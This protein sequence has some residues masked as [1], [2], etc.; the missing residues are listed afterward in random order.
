MKM[1]KIV[2]ISGS[3]RKKGYTMS[4]VKIIEDMMKKVDESIEFKY[5]YLRDKDLK[6]CLGCMNCLKVG[7]NACP[8]KDDASMILE[9]M[10]SADGLIFA[11]PGYSHQVSGLYKNFMDRFM[12][13]DHLPEF[14]G[15]PAL[16][17]STVGGDGAGVIPK[18]MA[19]M[20]I[21]WWGCEIV[22]QM[23]IPF[24]YFEMSNKYHKK[25]MKKIETTA[26]DFYNELNNNIEGCPGR[27]KFW[28]SR[29][30]IEADYYYDTK[31]KLIYKIIC[32]LIINYFVMMLKMDLGKDYKEKIAEWTKTW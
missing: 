9:E 11:S 28:K 24:L 2:V 21:T 18:Y 1:K 10:H 13:L 8:R 15:V 27:Y 17:V 7:G 26:V 32:S 3:P 16:V 14:V 19:N 25:M 23:G 31:V 30:W 20:G 22:G 12:Y 4:I 5:V 6:F 29:G